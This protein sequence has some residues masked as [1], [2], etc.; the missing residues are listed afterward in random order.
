MFHSGEDLGK[1]L[2]I[3]RAAVWKKIC[4]IKTLGRVVIDDSDT[5]NLVILPNRGLFI[6]NS[7]RQLDGTVLNETFIIV[8]DNPNK[9][10]Y[11][12]PLSCGGLDDVFVGRIRRDESRINS[13]NMWVVSDNL[14][15]GAALNAIQIAEYLIDK[16]LLTDMS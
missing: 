8:Y 2:D 11:P 9:N 14:R 12:M 10:H 6:M 7:D 15:K 3:T 13:L 5:N 4:K 16:K 1:K